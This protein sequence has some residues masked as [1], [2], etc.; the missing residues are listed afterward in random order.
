MDEELDRLRTIFEADITRFERAMNT[1]ANR[2]EAAARRAEKSFTDANKKIAASTDGMARDV[3]RAVAGIAVAVGG[4]E[5]LQYEEQWRN[6]VNTLKQY[7][8]V[9]GDASASA[10]DLNKIATEAAVPLGSLG[11]LTGA[12]ARA[13]KDLGKSRADVLSFVEGVSKGAQISNN[14]AAAVSGAITQLS[15]AIAS[16]RVQLGE[17]NSIIEGTPRLAQAF[18]DGVEIAGGSLAKLRQEIGKGNVSGED[19]FQGLLSQTDKLDS[20]FATLTTGVTE[21]FIRLQNQLAE[22]VGSNQGVQDTVQGLATVINFVADNLDSFANAA[23][24]AAAVMGGAFAGQGLLA[25]IDGFGKITK[26]AT[27]A[28][29]AM[30]IFGTVTAVFGGPVP[31]LIGGIAAA[32]AVLAINGNSAEKAMKAAAEAGDA[33][34][35]TLKET[36]AFLPPEARGNVFTDLKDSVEGAIPVV[37]ELAGAL[38]DVADAF[39][40]VVIVEFVQKL[41]DLEVRASGARTELAKLEAERAKA[42]SFTVKGETFQ[43]DTP[44]LDKGILE[45][46]AQIS[47]IEGERERYLRA[48]EGEDGGGSIGAA[49]LTGGLD[50]AAA[51]LRQ[52]LLDAGA[53]PGGVDPVPEATTADD[54]ARAAALA[55]IDELASATRAAFEDEREQLAR[56]RDERL[57]AIDAAGKSQAESDRLRQD[58]QDLYR[59]GIDEIIVREGLADTELA[60]LRRERLAGEQAFVDEVIASRDRM[61][62]RVQEIAQREHEF[63]RAEIEREI[64]DATLKQQALDAIDSEYAEARRQARAQLLG[65]GDRENTLDS[66]I[67]RIRAAEETKLNALK[68]GLAAQLI[69]EAEFNDERLQLAQTT[70]ALIVEARRSTASAQL[71]AYE[72]LFANVGELFKNL[73]GENSKAARVALGISRAFAIADSGIKIAQAGA[74]VLADPTQVTLPQK[75]AAAS[76]IAAQGAAILAAI[77]G[78]GKGFA[79]G[80]F[81]T[82][83]GGP[84][85]DSIPARLS[86]GEFVVNADSTR[87]NR[88]LLEAINSGRSLSLAQPAVQGAGAVVNVINNAPG[89]MA[90]EQRNGR[91][92]I[93]VIIEA[94]AQDIARGGGQVG[95]ALEGRYGVNPTGGTW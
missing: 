36:R 30:R 81:V 47:I 71:T 56:V 68:D 90:R 86:N 13:A 84:R 21:A 32:F 12:A 34:N 94:I 4:R 42:S 92:E 43:L 29:A 62:G 41:G 80:G 22:F 60:R 11:N 15:Q 1:Y 35:D 26:G 28:T 51:E 67:A 24:V 38:G 64:T 83:P 2:T 3:R 46:R 48:L 79:D 55:T 87:A 40:D 82:G 14:G 18:A 31:L 16:P 39:S 53:R 50:A 93:E 23:V 25:V 72:G 74:Q 66:E 52:R 19:L 95:M 8:A 59:L 20:E 7:S 70:D 27:A 91:G 44:N 65:L 63:R 6:T 17:F 88:Q 49:L 73:N 78:G 5:I 45:L 85:T 37:D 33:I 61:F 69:T 75:I 10:A 77:T 57:A 89:T 76:V 58:A 9:L 54:S